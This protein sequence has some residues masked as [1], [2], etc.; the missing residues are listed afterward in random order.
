MR[1]S[2]VVRLVL[3]VAAQTVASQTV[4]SQTA[5]ADEPYD[6]AA[7]RA[8][9]R[10]IF[11]SLRVLLPLAVD[12]GAF[13]DPA[14]A[15]TIERGLERIASQAAL[16]GSH[17]RGFDAGGRYLGR[18]LERDSTRA[19]REYQQGRY[20]ISAFFVEQ[21]TGACVG[22]HARLPAA[23]ADLARS[24]AEAPE[25]AP[26]DV[27]ERARLQVATRRFDDA[28]ASFEQ[29]FAAPDQHV[30]VLLGP[31]TDYL[32]VCV[33]VKDDLRRPVSTLEAMAARPEAWTQLR[34]DLRAWSADLKRFSLPGERPESLADAR[35]ALRQ[36]RSRALYPSDRRPLVEYL[37]ASA[38]LHRYVSQQRE[39]SPELAEA[40]YLLGLAEI[41]IGPDLWVSPA[42]YFL[43]NAVRVAPQT[44]YA[45]QAYALLEDET[46]AGF[47]GSAGVMVPADVQVHLEELRGLLKHAPASPE[48]EDT[49]G[50][51]EK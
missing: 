41:R 33:R 23:D 9:M 47:T 31:L 36:A 24:F 37:V 17:S 8:T 1:A 46:I 29:A 35:A 6:R 34:S 30:A 7:T 22:C 39:P 25:L 5:F 32:T 16:L 19:L 28:L 26:L 18:S 42:H 20:E 38:A 13:A 43:E 2:L 50:E 44:V 4:A 48:E 45:E 11:D 14:R 49:E 3:L 40:Y 10:E 27:L 15:E 21:M 12:S 51:P